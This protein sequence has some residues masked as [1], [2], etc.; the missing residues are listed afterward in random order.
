[1]PDANRDDLPGN[2]PASKG[3]PALESGPGLGRCGNASARGVTPYLQCG[4]RRGAGDGYPHRRHEW[5]NPE[6]VDGEIVAEHVRCHLGRDAWQR[7]RQ[8]ADRAHAGFDGAK[9]MLDPLPT[10]TPSSLVF[11]EPALN[12]FKN[13]LVFPSRDAALFP[14]VH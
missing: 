6:D 2:L 3:E 1:M 13:V 12:R 4:I 8:E 5:P 9:R 10:P 7:F 14:V 11:I